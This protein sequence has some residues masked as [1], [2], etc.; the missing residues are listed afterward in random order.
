METVRT[1][2]NAAILAYTGA[3]VVHADLDLLLRDPGSTTDL[4]AAYGLNGRWYDNGH[5]AVFNL[6]ATLLPGAGYP[7]SSLSYATNPA[8][9]ANSSPISK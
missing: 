7:P 3:G 9:Y 8:S 6:L 4:A 1:T 2:F 5:T